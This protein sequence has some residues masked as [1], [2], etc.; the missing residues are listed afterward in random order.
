MDKLAVLMELMDEE[1]LR[2]FKE[3]LKRGVLSDMGYASDG[4]SPYDYQTLE[5]LL[6]EEGEGK[7]LRR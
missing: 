7:R 2:Q 6:D 5:S 3:T 1:E 4:E